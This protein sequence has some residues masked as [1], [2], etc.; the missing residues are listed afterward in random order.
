MALNPNTTGTVGFP[1]AIAVYYDKMLLD[2]LEKTLQF[3]QFAEKKKLPKN[4]G[5]EI[6]FTRYSNFAANTTPLTEATTPS[7]L[8]L[9]STQIS[10]IPL[11]YGDFVTLSDYLIAEA[12]DPVI[13]GALDVLSYRAAL[14]L[15]TII[16]NTL[17]NAVTNQF[18][19]GVANEAAV[20]AVM[21][22]SEVRKAVYALKVNAVRPIGSDYA[23]LIHPAQSFDLQSDTA[24]GS[25]LDLNKYTTTGPLYKGEIGK[26]YGARCVESQNVQVAAGAGSGGVDVIRAYLF[27]KGAYGLVELAG[28]NLKTIVKQLGSAGSEDPLDQRSTVGYKFSHVTKVLDS[29]RAIEIYTAT[30]AY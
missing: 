7:G 15:D 17:H 19:A 16:R 27:G 11:Q 4:S 30:A 6:K 25:W 13:E 24:A 5:N 9:Q 20:A 8:T 10:A 23:L 3:D 14:S 22:A 1:N 26:L 18:A 12:I 28:N 2:R 21:T 29:T